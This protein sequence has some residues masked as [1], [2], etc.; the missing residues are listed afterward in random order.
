MELT[1]AM[2][3]ILKRLADL[4]SKVEQ[5]DVRI[6]A[7]ESNVIAALDQLGDYKNRTDEELSSMSGRVD[8]LINSVGSL[9]A[10]SEYGL[11]TERAKNLRRRLLNNKTRIDKQINARRSRG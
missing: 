2:E 7:F 6:T 5:I 3:E 11:A 8:A 9:V 1:V 4:E 10:F